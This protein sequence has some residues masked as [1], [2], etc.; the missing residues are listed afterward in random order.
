MEPNEHARERFA[1]KPT[2]STS[3]LHERQPHKQ[4]QM[5]WVCFMFLWDCFCILQSGGLFLEF[6]SFWLHF[7]A[8]ISH[9]HA[10]CCILGP[11]SLIWTVFAPFWTLDLLLAEK[12]AGSGSQ[13]LHNICIIQYRKLKYLIGM[14]FVAFWRN[15]LQFA[16]VC[17][18]LKMKPVL[19]V[20][21]VHCYLHVFD[22]VDS[23]IAAAY[24]QYFGFL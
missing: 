8:K 3:M 22:L 13:H 10:I 2:R 21:Y 23:T 17:Y 5:I 24:W 15:N 18:M 11:K 19:I 6:A 12:F 16:W 1:C 7:G 9:L 14:V 4:V 20:I